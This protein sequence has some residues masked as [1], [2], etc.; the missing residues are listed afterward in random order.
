MIKLVNFFLRINKYLDKYPF[1]HIY[2]KS[3]ICTCSFCK[4]QKDITIQ[5]I[6]C[7]LTKKLF[8]RNFDVIHR[9]KQ[10]SHLIT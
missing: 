3:R 8:N 5:N 6:K 10:S 1:I 9:T 7:K 2:Q 4:F